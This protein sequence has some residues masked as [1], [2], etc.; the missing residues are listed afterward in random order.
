VL[1]LA[2]ITKHYG[3][4]TVLDA[5]TL[6]VGPGEK[7][8]LVG[9]N[10]AGKTTLLRITCGDEEPDAGAV[11]LANGWVVG[12][13]PQDAGVVDERTVW[14]EMLAAHADLA[15]LQDEIAA[16]ETDLHGDLA[17]E[18]LARLVDHQADLIARFE[19]RGGYRVEAEI[20]K[21]LAGLG[22]REEDLKKRTDQ[23]SG[24]WRTRIALAKLLVR[25]PDLLLLD[26][27]T[28]HL[29]IDATEWLETYL[30]ASSASAIVVSHDRYF[31][32]RTIS[33]TVELEDGK[34]T[35]FAGTY[36]F[37]VG[38]KA[39][40]PRRPRSRVARSCSPRLSAS[41]LRTPRRGRSR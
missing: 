39:R 22:F 6:S 37:Y 21:V 17:D 35:E 12:Y 31:L 38:E 29:D 33:R 11:Q 13:L 15:R 9:A 20:H 1:R 5:A 36:S 8:A 28:N 30:K 14:D 41:R 16:V 18:E 3:S 24:G 19:A 10:G 7:I 2:E 23:F 26:E 34:L 32:E 4:R 27:P 40:P 25:S